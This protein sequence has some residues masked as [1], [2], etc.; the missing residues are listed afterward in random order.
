MSLTALI[1]QVRSRPDA[2]QIG[3]ILSHTGIVR[4]TSR[5]GRRVSGFDLSVDW[6]KLD[7]IVSEHKKRPGIVEILIEI[8]EGFLSVG[9]EV[10]CLVVAGSIR[11]QVIPTLQDTLNAIKKEVTSKR[12]HFL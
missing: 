8:H 5:D 6:K 3:M 12:E 7:A 2:S 10:M 11:D 4:G 1:D 9:D